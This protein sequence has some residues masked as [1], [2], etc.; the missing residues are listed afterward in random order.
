[1]TQLN[2][3]HATATVYRHNVGIS[4]S[5]GVAQVNELV[6]S[7]RVKVSLSLCQP[8]S[9]RLFADTLALVSNA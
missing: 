2:E 5:D 4:A 8:L 1:M 3:R 9:H 7:Q 6:S